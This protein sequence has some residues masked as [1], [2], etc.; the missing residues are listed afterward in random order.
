MARAVAELPD[1]R[2]NA[3]MDDAWLAWQEARTL[4]YNYLTFDAVEY[5]LSGH[6]IMLREQFGQ[7]VRTFA[8]SSRRAL[9]RSNEP[10]YIR[11]LSYYEH[12]DDPMAPRDG[13]HRS[14]AVSRAIRAALSNPRTTELEWMFEQWR[15]HWD[16]IIVA[17]RHNSGS[18]DDNPSEGEPNLPQQ[19]TAAA[20]TNPKINACYY[21]AVLQCLAH[22]SSV[23][24]VTTHDRHGT[25]CPLGT[26]ACWACWLDGHLTRVWRTREA[27]TPAN[28]HAN[29][30]DIA[31]ELVGGHM[32]DPCVFLE[33]LLNH[34][35]DVA[36]PVARIT[37]GTFVS[38]CSCSNPTC[39]AESP[40]HDSQEPL[41]GI[42]RLPIIG[43]STVQTALSACVSAPGTVTGACPQ[44]GDQQTDLT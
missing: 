12:S 18:D 22:A 27:Y 37:D 14:S 20:L 21:N 35:R 26:E 42:L 8:A 28:L 39:I 11:S 24:R 16:R 4:L 3:D 2:S 1:T 33:G 13:A 44:C 19:D 9:Y 6:D 36:S 32:S 10:E 23:R 7:G 17:G 25:H 34:M 43:H 38:R 29:L 5:V 15:P 30:G 31:A 40:A 41:R